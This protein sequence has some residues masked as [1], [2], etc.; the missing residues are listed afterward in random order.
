MSSNRRTIRAALATLLSSGVTSAQVVYAYQPGD[1]GGQSPAVCVGSAGS[2]RLAMTYQG[3]RARMYFDIDVFVLTGEA[4]PSAYGQ[5]S[6]EDALDNVEAE[7][8]AVVASNANQETANWRALDYAGRSETDFVIV[9]G[10]EYKR[11]K[12]PI[13][14][15]VFS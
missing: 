4:A 1:F 2:E 8:A 13:A 9:D 3:D 12:I 5:D 7:I 14:I 15:T 11:E 6:S 10:R